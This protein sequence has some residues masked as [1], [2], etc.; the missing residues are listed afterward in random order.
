M[1]VVS[2]LT[3][4]YGARP[5]LRHA[6]ISVSVGEIVA[7]VGRN[8]AGKTTLLKA[9]MGLLPILSG[10]VRLGSDDITS[11]PTHQR[12]R[13]G[14]GYVPQGRPVFSDLT[15]WEHLQLAVDLDPA[16]GRHRVE[17][18]LQTFPRIAR[19]FR[20]SAAT[21]SGGEQQLLALARTLASGPKLLLLDEPTAG[22]QP[23]IVDEIVTRLRALSAEQRL[24]IILVEHNIELVSALCSRICVM[25]HGRIVT[26][27]GPE[28]IGDESIVRS[29]LAI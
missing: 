20:Q 5:V 29:Y 6:E 2:D 27:I 26:E 22:V 3:V 14:L 9:I 7:V 8:A 23:S 11:L 21:L 17:S 16:G 12:A 24:P 25:D 15:V 1:L 4:S 13:R 18:I 10:T 28:H 19:R